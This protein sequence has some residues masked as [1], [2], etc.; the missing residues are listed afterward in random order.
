MAG[1]TRTR[2]VKAAGALAATGF[3]FA[4]APVRAAE[5]AVGGP[6][7]GALPMDQQL[8]RIDQLLPQRDVTEP[9]KGIDPLIFAL[10]VPAD[11]QMTP[12]RVALGKKLYFDTRLSA[13]GTVAC[14]TCHD[15]S[16]GFTDQ[17]PVSEGIR[18]QLGRR[19]APTTLERRRAADRSSWTGAPPTLE[20]Q[21]KLPILNPI[22]MGQ[23]DGKAVIA[24]D[25]QRPGLPAHVPGRLR[26]RAELRGHRAR[27]RRLRA[28]AGLPRLAVRQFLA[29]QTDAIS[30]AGAGGL[31]AVQ[32]QGALRRAATS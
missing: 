27:D 11:N 3:L 4:G 20:D 6:L 2:W 21:A 28:D 19:N 25:R 8:A 15:V 1:A 10:F 26:A 23:P 30:A 29:G 16:R 13:D 17:R 7:H 31:G 22:E 12:A 24:G 32:R 9:P 18:D 5:T 14:A